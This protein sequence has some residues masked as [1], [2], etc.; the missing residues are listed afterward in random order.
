MR[1]N[2]LLISIMLISLAFT[3]C[4]QNVKNKDSSSLK[5]LKI[6]DP[7]PIPKI[8]AMKDNKWVLLEP[9]SVTYYNKNNPN[10][11]Y[12]IEVPAGF[13]MDLASIPKGFRILA[14]KYHDLD[15]AAIV[16]D[17]LFWVQPCKNE[18]NG[19][20][21]A[22]K[23]YRDTLK[24]SEQVNWA[25]AWYQWIALKSGSR[26]AWKNNRN[27]KEK[28]ESRFMPKKYWPK[29]TKQKKWS[30]LKDECCNKQLPQDFNFSN[31]EICSIKPKE[32]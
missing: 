4:A 26:K 3:G 2:I 15:T 17:Y 24:E 20:R 1:I 10:E 8:S 16:H 19:K 11:T 25:N 6:N 9:L 22:D 30:E 13:V 23:L 7:Y 5:T 31:N 18:G 32:R 14:G 27:L 29:V 28:G 12:L 21:I